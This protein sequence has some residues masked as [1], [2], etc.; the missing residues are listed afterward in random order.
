MQ[1]GIEEKV[2]RSVRIVVVRCF[3][4]KEERHKCKECLLWKKEHRLVCP[5]KGKAHQEKKPAYLERGKA[6]EVRRV[7]KGEAV[8]PVK[9]KVQQEEWKRSSWEVLRKRAKWYCGPTV[10]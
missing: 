7:E 10:P 8:R 6:Q 1:C 4:C 5:Y 3:K 2:V 9:R